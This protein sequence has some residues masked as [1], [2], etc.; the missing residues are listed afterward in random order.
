MTPSN[1]SSSGSGKVTLKDIAKRADV[2]TAL[3]SCIL[4]GKGRASEKVRSK[5]LALLEEAGYRP[6]Y[7]R[8]SFFYLLDLNRITE[9]GK[10]IPVMR[11]LKGAEQTLDEDGIHLQ[12]EFIS[13]GEGDASAPLR[14]PR[15]NSGPLHGQSLREQLEF[16]LQSQP[17]AVFVGTD[18]PWLDRAC[19]FFDK[20]GVPLMQMGY[21]TEIPRYS[22]VVVDSFSGAH[23]ATRLLLEHGHRRVATLR[24]CYAVA[25]VNSNRK[26]AGYSAALT[27]AGLSV[28][29]AYVKTITTGQMESRWTPARTCLEEL[30]RLPEPPTALFV[31]NSFVSMPLLYSLPGDHG[32]LPPAVRGLDMVHFEDW[33]L[34]PAEDIAAGKLGHQLRST[35]V[36]AI[37]WEAIG[38][39]AARM[40]VEKV[41]GT[42]AA[43]PG[44]VRI[45][46]LLQQLNGNQRTTIDTNAQIK[47]EKA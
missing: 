18:E 21:D 45:A 38:R 42:G 26:F 12:V 7:A 41:R 39:L 6:R 31:E 17:G 43:Q 37:E 40:L 25:A 14:S 29:P 9:S 11:M 24:W 22:A 28:D 47:G 15:S 1:R 34:D 27:D 3:V 20:A 30:L 19:A 36:L 35:T 2:S 10:T 33:P 5:V 23:S 13:S 44:V 32:S 8:K 4:N 46:P 16:I